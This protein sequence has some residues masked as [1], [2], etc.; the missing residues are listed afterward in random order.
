MVARK[1]AVKPNGKT[2]TAVNP[3]VP[4]MAKP[5]PV[6]SAGKS[7]ASPAM[8]NLGIESSE[9]VATRHLKI[10][11]W[12]ATATRK[13]ETVL[14]NFPGVLVIDA[15]GNTDQCV[16]N[17]NIP[18]FL[19]VKTT[20]T[21]KVLEIVDALAKGQIKMQDG[22]PVQTLCIDSVSVLW[23]V[24]Q[25][26]ASS[27]AEQ[28]AIRYNKEIDQAGTTPLDWVK[29]KR[30]LKMLLNRFAKTQVP[31]LILIAREKDLFAELPGGELKK[32]GVTPNAVK[33]TEYDMNLGLH[34][35]MNEGQRWGY[36]VTKVQGGLVDLFPLG[37]KGN[38]LPLDKLFEYA[39]IL[40][41]DA[42]EQDNGED[43]SLPDR[44]AQTMMDDER[45][46]TQSKLIEYATTKGFNAQSLGAIL[47]A[48]GF[49]GF[50]PTRWS[51]MIKAIDDAASTMR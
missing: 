12:G 24:Q 22:S 25:E 35:S 18:A 45:N 15:E 27:L 50:D 4:E 34:F 51:E 29:A 46:H 37:G 17:K 11:F 49:S 48:A 5:A 23:G 28:R 3:A 26:V 8:K 41:P 19:R 44:I 7:P 14:R 38:A 9:D 33:D 20:D 10:M 1:S 21:R 2:A 30:P 6:S 32:I 36:E 16:Q 13:T 31:Y 42:P 43:E 40:R 39:S 47:K